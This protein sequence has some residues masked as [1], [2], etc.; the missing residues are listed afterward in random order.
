M[1]IVK[2]DDTVKPKWRVF[3]YGKPGTGKTTLASKI[4]GKSFILSLDQSYM[5][6]E[7]MK[8]KDIWSL[9]QNNPIEDINDFVE[10]FNPEGYDNLI[11]DNITTLQKTWFVEKAK[12][13]G[14]GLDNKIQHYG[15][16]TNYCI[17]LFAKI[18]SYPLNVF[19]TAHETQIEFTNAEGQT[20]EQYAPDVRAGARDHIMGL[21]D[22]VGRMAINPKTG[23]RGVILVGNDGVFAK[24][25]WD[26][27][28]AC[29]ADELFKGK[30]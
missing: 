25:C 22:I 5:R 13:T 1:P 7:G 16:F 15:E 27:R 23:G 21:C 20:F 14:N 29:P 9:D 6:V 8:G 2:F 12:E 28:T 26:D 18:F 4:P 30:E 24:N 3:V 11:V 17:R 19:V 10:S